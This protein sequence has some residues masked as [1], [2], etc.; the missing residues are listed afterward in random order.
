[1]AGRL[2]WDLSNERVRFPHNLIAA[3]DEAAAGTALLEQK[4]AGG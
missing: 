4:G 1:M 3:H 2:G